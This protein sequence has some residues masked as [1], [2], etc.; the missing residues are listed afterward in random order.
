[1]PSTSFTLNEPPAYGVP[2]TTYHMC[3]GNRT[4]FGNCKTKQQL[5]VKI[6]C[7]DR[8]FRAI[9]TWTFNCC[10]NVGQVFFIHMNFN[11]LWRLF[12]QITQFLCHLTYY[13]WVYILNVSLC[14]YIKIT[15][16][17]TKNTIK[18]LHCV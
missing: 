9:F 2:A 18:Q 16:P 8:A 15:S 17:H 7:A 10:L 1:M 4:Y 14:T 13:L 12:L 3:F 11:S 6:S 5:Y